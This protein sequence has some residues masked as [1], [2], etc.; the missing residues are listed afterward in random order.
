MIV[1]KGNKQPRKR[2]IKHRVDS[3]PR[4]QIPDNDKAEIKSLIVQLVEGLTS[5]GD[6]DEDVYL[7]L[8]KLSPRKNDS[9][10]LNKLILDVEVWNS[11]NEDFDEEV[12]FPVAQY[13]EE[14][15]RIV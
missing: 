1:N 11:Y 7:N 5:T 15:V 9:D 10:L 6:V 8:I 3:E 13:Y 14:L 2:V 4:E 12:E